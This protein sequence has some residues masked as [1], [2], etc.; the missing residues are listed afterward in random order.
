VVT[1]EQRRTAVTVARETA[2]GISERRAC[3]FTGFARS[4][5]RYVARRPPRTELRQRLRTLA[6]QRPRW[7]YRRL[8]LLLGREGY[9]VN[10]KL[11]ERIYREEGLTVRRRRAKKQIAIPRVALPLPAGPPARMS[12]GAWTL[13]RMPWATRERFAH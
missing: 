2:G 8:H 12:G 11:V 4:S 6:G 13:C 10:R 7:G 9:A 3:R 5:Q 1:P